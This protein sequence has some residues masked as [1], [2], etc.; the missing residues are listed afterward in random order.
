MQK[1]TEHIIKYKR[2]LIFIPIMAFIVA[3]VVSF[4]VFPI[5]YEKYPAPLDPD[6]YSDIAR[7]IVEYGSFSLYPDTEPT[8]DRGPVYPLFLALFIWVFGDNGIYAAIIA[9]CAIFAL[10][11]LLVFKIAGSFWERKIAVVAGVVCALHP[12][13]FQYA[14]KILI[15]T[16]AVFLFTAI[17]G[18]TLYLYR[19]PSTVK[20]VLLGLVVGIASLTKAT[21]L[22]F[23]ILIPLATV[24][25]GDRKW[26]HALIIFIIGTTVIAPW[27]IRN[28]SLTGE[29][30]P[31]HT[32]AGTNFQWGDNYVDN[33]FKAPLSAGKLQQISKP[34][35]HEIT[36]RWRAEHPGVWENS[37]KWQKDAIE[38]SVGMAVS[39][40]RYRENPLF[41]VKKVLLNA[42]MFWTLGFNTLSS[43]V[44]ILL[45]IPLLVLFIPGAR[46]AL[47]MDDIRSVSSLHIAMVLVYFLLHLPIFAFARLSVVMLPTM[48]IYAVGSD[49]IITTVKGGAPRGG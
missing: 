8:T 41:L 9:Q 46:R 39:M 47:S 14:G 4:V 3:L 37:A 48:I 31:V 5:A 24:F 35:L 12:L 33:Y 15:E 1:N 21:F 17:T 6:R 29:F 18:A 32:T 38:D 19:K 27:T 40:A 44:I 28:Y 13:L 10:T 36:D 22:P 43:T 11:A 20:A 2:A 7:G 26:K 30:V 45:Q 16:L 23:L 49:T 25:S 34:A 42:V